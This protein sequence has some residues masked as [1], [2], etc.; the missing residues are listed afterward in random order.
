MCLA[1]GSSITTT[2]H[3]FQALSDIGISDLAIFSTPDG[4]SF[5]VFYTS[6]HRN[7]C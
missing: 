4:T 5:L 3:N 6:F 2:D 7:V 1:E